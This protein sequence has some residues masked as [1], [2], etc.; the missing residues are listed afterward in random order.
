MNGPWLTFRQGAA[1]Q[2]LRSRSIARL[3][4]IDRWQDL[5]CERRPASH[6]GRKPKVPIS[7]T[8]VDRLACD[9]WIWM[10]LSLI[11]PFSE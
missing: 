3:T 9:C 2:K 7:L 11:I 10:Q 4:L 1:R 6:H 5:P 8:V